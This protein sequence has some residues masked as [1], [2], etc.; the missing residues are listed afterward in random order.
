MTTNSTS[1]NDKDYNNIGVDKLDTG[2]YYEAITHFNKAVE[3]NPYNSGAYFN[4]SLAWQGINHPL[5]AIEDLDKAIELNPSYYKAFYQRGN[6]NCDI[7]KYDLAILD[8]DKAIFF[9]DQYFEA[10]NNRG[11]VNCTLEN[12]INAIEDYN[13]A[14]DINPF[15]KEAYFNRAYAY[16]ELRNYSK[17]IEDLKKAIEIDKNFVLPYRMLGICQYNLGLFDEAKLNIEIALRLGDEDAEE[18]LSL[19]DSYK[20]IDGLPF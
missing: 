20:D 19:F 3:I 17:A 4:R 16:S 2:E 11:H 1:M 8:Y 10:Y 14:L 13:N 7:S 12:Y 6:I 15:D 18:L 9:N 5:R